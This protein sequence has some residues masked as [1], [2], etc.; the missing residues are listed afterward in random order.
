MDSTPHRPRRAIRIAR[1]LAPLIL[2]LFALAYL[3]IS[4][5]AAD[6]LT[7]PSNQPDWLDPRLVS[8]HATAWSV[9]TQDG[10]TLRG[11]YCPTS[12]H[13][14]LIV[15]VHGKGGSWPEM[16][17][18]GRDLHA[19]GYDVLLFDL[20]GHGR[21]DP[22][23]LSMGRRERGDLRAALAWADRQ[24]FSD[25]RIGWLGQSMGA[26]TI[27]MEAAR[28]PRI[29][30]AVL[31][32]PYGHLP[33]LLHEQLPKMSHLPSWFTPGILTAA[34][35]AYGIRTD[36]LIPITAARL[37]GRRPLLLIHGE[38]DSIVPVDQAIRLARAAGPSC[39]A[40]TLPGVGH[41]QAFEVNP[42]RYVA[43]VDSFFRRNLSP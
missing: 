8:P 43:A 16:A 10:L 39:Q 1:G 21:S 23:R 12:R 22:A 9:R 34:R 20:R 37:W 24:G 13:R 30:V 26:S 18:R 41:V 4:L 15:L 14:H 11:W 19:Y 29:R 32:S 3:G 25:D 42:R 7:R 27:L 5:L 35:L 6:H 2:M 17:A 28:N 36:D 33:E 40:V 38:A 31:D